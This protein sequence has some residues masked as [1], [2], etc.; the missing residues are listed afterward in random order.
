MKEEKPGIFGS[1]SYCLDESYWDA[2]VKLLCIPWKAL[3]SLQIPSHFEKAITI[4]VI[5]SL[6]FEDRLRLQLLAN[7]VEWEGWEVHLGLNYR[8]NTAGV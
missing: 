3:L 1:L 4:R 2:E 7:H 5:T 6:C 8:Q